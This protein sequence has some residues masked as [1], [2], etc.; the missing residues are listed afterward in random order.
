MKKWLLQWRATDDHIALAPNGK[1]PVTV[2][3]HLV[4][5]WVG[6]KKTRNSKILSNWCKGAKV[7]PIMHRGLDLEDQTAFIYATVAMGCKVNLFPW[8]LVI[9]TKW[10]CGSN[11]SKIPD[12]H[13]ISLSDIDPVRKLEINVTAPWGQS[14]Q[15]FQCDSRFILWIHLWL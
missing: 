1:C 8:G 9:N 3:S 6:T 4:K 7:N 11:R 2:E 15:A 10:S 14:I 13:V 5:I 12:I